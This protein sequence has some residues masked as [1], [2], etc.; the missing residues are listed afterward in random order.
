MV[1]R[2]LSEEIRDKRVHPMLCYREGGIPGAEQLDFEPSRIQLYNG[3]RT[4]LS[5]ALKVAANLRK[6]ESEVEQR[7]RAEEELSKLSLKD[8]LTGLYNR[9]G[10]HILTEEQLTK[11]GTVGKP[12]AI[13]YADMDELKLINDNNGHAAGDIALKDAAGALSV[14]VRDSDIV[15]RLGGDEFG[16]F[17]LLDTLEHARMVKTRLEKAVAEAESEGRRRGR[18]WNLSMSFGL[19]ASDKFSVKLD[20]LLADADQNLYQEKMNKRRSR[21]ESTTG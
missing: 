8:E 5:M 1:G 12:Y 7:R 10:F 18:E 11:A 2:F 4:R 16:L 3:I 15:A 20:K 13:V 9:R 17:V 6:L 19:V 21:N 14:S